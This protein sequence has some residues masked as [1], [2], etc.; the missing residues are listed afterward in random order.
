MRRY[1]F[2]KFII[3]RR[4]MW[5]S[6]F[7]CGSILFKSLL[8]PSTSSQM[9]IP[10]PYVLHVQHGPVLLGLCDNNLSL[11]SEYLPIFFNKADK[12]K[13]LRGYGNKYVVFSQSFHF[14]W[15]LSALHVF[16]MLIMIWFFFSILYIACIY[17]LTF[18]KRE[19]TGCSLNIVFFFRRF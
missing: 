18:Y 17:F 4:E 8:T 10:C 11:F 6:F 9:H 15:I 2:T 5:L 19:D 16:H 14:F 13:P 3:Y 1:C 7:G 12:D